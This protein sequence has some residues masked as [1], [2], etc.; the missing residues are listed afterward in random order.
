MGIFYLEVKHIMRDI[1]NAIH[2]LFPEAE[3]IS[4]KK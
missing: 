2:Y 4:K 3:K 1:N